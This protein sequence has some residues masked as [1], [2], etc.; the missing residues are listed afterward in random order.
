[1]STEAD[2]VKRM[3]KASPEG[4]SATY[5]GASTILGRIFGGGKSS[6]DYRKGQQ[7]K[8]ERSAADW[9]NET[10]QAAHLHRLE[11]NARNAEYMRTEG[12]ADN[13]HIRNETAA[14]AEH[15]RT[16][17]MAKH[18]AN[19]GGEG[20]TPSSMEIGNAKIKYANAPKSSSA[21]KNSAAPKAPSA[22]RAPRAPKA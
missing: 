7:F 4:K 17:A 5:F 13:A 9:Q 19:L 3:A 14:K 20:R 11:Q 15:G 21:S 18:L 6:S 16:K 2:N 22:P 12:A 1:M 8:Q 10:V